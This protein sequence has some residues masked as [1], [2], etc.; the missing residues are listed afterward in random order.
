MTEIIGYILIVVG[1]L[2]NIFGCIGLVRF[3]DHALD[4]ASEILRRKERRRASAQ[5]DFADARSVR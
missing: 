1:I 4:E 3:L 2:F 5:V